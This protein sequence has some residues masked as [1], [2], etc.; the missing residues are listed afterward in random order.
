MV[1]FG[2]VHMCQ[3]LRTCHSFVVVVVVIVIVVIIVTVSYFIF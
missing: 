2:K 1:S 3:N